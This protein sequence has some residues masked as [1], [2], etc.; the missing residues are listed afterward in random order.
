MVRA[1]SIAVA[2]L[3]RDAEAVDAYRTAVAFTDNAAEQAFLTARAA[4]LS[5]CL[6]S[7]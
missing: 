2:R 3:G 1:A 7:G 5:A 4:V 6:S